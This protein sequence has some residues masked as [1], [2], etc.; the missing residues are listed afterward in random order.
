MFSFLKKA[1]LVLGLALFSLTSV[2]NASDYPTLTGAFATQLT[3][4]ASAP[5]LSY[6]AGGTLAATTYYVKFGYVTAIGFTVPS[7]ESSLAVPANNLLVINPPQPLQGE[8]SY[9]VGIGTTSGTNYDTS[10]TAGQYNFTTYTPNQI[11]TEPVGGFV[12]S[13]YNIS[14]L[15]PSNASAYGQFQV[16]NLDIQGTSFGSLGFIDVGVT[17]HG[18]NPLLTVP[19]GGGVNITDPTNI[20]TAG[21]INFRNSVASNFGNVNTNG[22]NYYSSTYGTN[23]TVGGYIR[24]TGQISVTGGLTYGVTGM[25]MAYSGAQG[26]F[27]IPNVSGSYGFYMNNGAL[28]APLVASALTTVTDASGQSIKMTGRSSDNFSQIVGFKNDGTTILDLIQN[29]GNGNISFA[30]SSSGTSLVNSATLSSTQFVVSGAGTGGANSALSVPA[31]DI[32]TARANSTGVI[33]L[34]NSGAYVYF[35][36]TNYQMPGHSLVLNGTTYTSKRALKTQIEN[37]DSYDALAVLDK[38]DHFYTY[39]YR[40]TKGDTNHIKY[41]D[42]PAANCKVDGRRIGFMADDKGMPTEIVGT[43]HDH[44]DA[45]NLAALDT[46]AIRQLQKQLA[47]QQNEILALSCAG[48]LLLVFVL[49]KRK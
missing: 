37:A 26:Q 13:P 23:A 33:Y 1:A 20:G 11:I 22:Y 39:C 7:T 18:G 14:L 48:F 12:L 25:D 28:Y 35:D 36:G 31:G 17:Y 16:G 19:N 40:A 9:Y 34:G 47:F 49:A 5:V 38:A 6:T 10:G 46:I 21:Q 15:T 45:G 44:V 29:V 4:P 32:Y 8:I 2:A 42:K 30:T 43:K 24:S 3:A 27:N 41:L